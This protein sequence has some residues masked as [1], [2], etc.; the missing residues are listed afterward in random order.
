MIPPVDAFDV[1]L[2]HLPPDPSA[3]VDDRVATAYPVLAS[4]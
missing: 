4:A 3:S 1:V 2:G